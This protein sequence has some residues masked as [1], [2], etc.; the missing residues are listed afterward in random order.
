MNGT[1][2]NGTNGNATA[3]NGTAGNGSGPAGRLRREDL[4]SLF[5]PP[6]AG[7]ELVGLEVENGVVDPET[8]RAARYG[9]PGGIE[10]VLRTV[11]EEWGGER[12]ADAGRL[13][14]VALPDGAR[15]TLEH[16]GQLEYSSVPLP[17]LAAAVDGTRE[18][19]ERLAELVGRFG[20]ALLPGAQLPFDRVDAMEW[21]P[22]VRGAVMRDY[23]RRLGAAGSGATRVMALSLSAQ[24]HL[25][26]LSER[27]FTEK[28]RMQMAASSTVTA[29]F[30]NSPLDNGRSNGLL[31]HRS[32]DWLRMDP[33][34]CGI[35]PP[36]LRDGVDADA[37]IDWALG[38]PMIYHR[39]PD[40]GYRPAPARPFGTIL[41]EGFDD[42]G[43]PQYG[44]WVS[45]MSQTWTAVRARRTLELRAGDGPPYRHFAAVPALWV[46]LSYHP[47][48]RAAAWE[49]LR[50]YS[51]ADHRAAMAA[52]PS[53]G[54]RT[55]L[56]GDRVHDLAAE[57]VRLARAGLS[58]RVGDGLEPPK[59]LDY[60]DPLD[61]LLHT[62]KTF[63]EQCAD[64][65]ATDLRHEPR[66]YVAEFRV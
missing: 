14:G 66:R 21:V 15:V 35:M 24:V 44:D 46:G 50:S 41:R 2:G 45:H 6:A 43:F 17:G 36:A 63:A 53:E 27:D 55:L 56:G 23:F 29:L 39:G 13:T 16:G 57:L 40:G 7:A 12:L 47:P 26:Y 34:R 8:G 10:E 62:R 28:L 52:L 11:L 33:D 22:M 59:V 30:V 51:A 49:L 38:L 19:L 65:W 58:A 1:N 64:R 5:A 20:L 60:L 48:S 4:R 18:V 54:L 31:S 25:D 32:R 37:V 3:G 9:G 42:G 61:E